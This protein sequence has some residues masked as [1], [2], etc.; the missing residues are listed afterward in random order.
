M[1]DDDLDYLEGRAQTELEMAQRSQ[2]PAV[3]AAL[4]AGGSLS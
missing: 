2:S 1:S 3:T 4:P